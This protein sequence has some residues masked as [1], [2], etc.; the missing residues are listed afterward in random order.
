MRANFYSRFHKGSNSS[1]Y[2]QLLKILED[3]DEY[4]WIVY[5]IY[6]NTREPGL[7]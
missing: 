7:F 1:V 6:G 2:E 4:K 5:I 3:K